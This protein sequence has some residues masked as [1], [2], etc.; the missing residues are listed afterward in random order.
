MCFFLCSILSQSDEHYSIYIQYKH[1]LTLTLTHIIS[2]VKLYVW[3]FCSL[4]FAFGQKEF[5]FYMPIFVFHFVAGIH[6]F[7]IFLRILFC[8]LCCH[9]TFTILRILLQQRH[10]LKKKNGLFTNGHFCLFFI[11][12]VNIHCYF[13]LFVFHF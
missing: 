13:S 6:L 4:Y 10:N 5:F 8:C 1:L 7:F 2:N 9:L 12:F 3:R 11:S